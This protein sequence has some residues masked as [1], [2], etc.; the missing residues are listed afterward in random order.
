MDGGS[1]R[2]VSERRG[3][4]GENMSQVSLPAPGTVLSPLPALLGTERRER[5]ELGIHAE[6]PVFVVA[7]G[8]FFP[9]VFQTRAAVSN[10]TCLDWR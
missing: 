7:A 2:V 3:A 5:R 8:L 4:G 10:R 9:P 1:G 6:F